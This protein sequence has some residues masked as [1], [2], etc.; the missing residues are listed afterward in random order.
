MLTCEQAELIDGH[1]SL[2][3]LG[4]RRHALMGR[5]KFYVG[6]MVLLGDVAGSQNIDTC[7]DAIS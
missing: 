5:I 3:A 7:C 2:P 1:K 6:R 4:G